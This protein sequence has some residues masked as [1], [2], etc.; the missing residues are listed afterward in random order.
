MPVLRRLVLTMAVATLVAAAVSACGP[1]EAG[2][3][4]VGFLGP[5]TGRTSDLGVDGRDG[6]LLAVEDRNAAGGV[7]GERVV[8]LAADA[9]QDAKIGRAAFESMVASGVLAVVGPMT[10]SVCETIVP[11]ADGAG[12]LLVSPT[13][14]S[15]A[16]SGKD[17]MLLRVM[18]DTRT[19]GEGLAELLAEHIGARTVAI[20][21]DEG[22]AAYSR[23][24]ADRTMESLAGSA[25]RVTTLVA[26]DSRSQPDL[27]VAAG[28]AAAA[29]PEAVLI[30]ASALDTA[31]LAG[32][33]R[34]VLPD[35]DIVASQWAA[36][37]QVIESGGQ[38]IE[39][40]YFHDLFDPDST[41]PA[42]LSF[43]D[44]FVERFGREPSFA[45]IN[46]YDAMSI[47]LDGLQRSDDPTELKA[48]ILGRVPYPG[49]QTE[50]G[51][52]ATGDVARRM[53]VLVIR[54]GRFESD[55]NR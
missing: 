26:F 29:R 50:L 33:L 49:L 5:L 45:A 28:R 13:V 2:T 52:D 32:Q 55:E 3:L 19:F 1:D 24:V 27:A 43:R 17:D 23:A 31:S 37:N 35:A 34:D 47:V 14:S 48:T 22:N 6:A 41:E 36:T 4:T 8:L 38:H 18:P 7:R 9:S 10:S 30:I 25:S 44:R 11:L 39:G 12:V 54:D 42:Y 51:F 15:D 21:L 53:F 16:F 20:I 40:A 46:A